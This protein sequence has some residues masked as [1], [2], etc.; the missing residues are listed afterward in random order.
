M[1]A[2]PLTRRY[3]GEAPGRRRPR[4]FRTAR[5]E[6]PASTPAATLIGS[7]AGRRGH[8]YRFEVDDRRRRPIARRA[9]ARITIANRNPN[10][11]QRGRGGGSRTANPSWSRARLPSI[12]RICNRFARVLGGCPQ[13]EYNPRSGRS[14]GGQAG[15]PEVPGA[16]YLRR[17]V[18]EGVEAPEKRGRPGADPGQKGSPWRRGRS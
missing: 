10:R 7:S 3:A 9:L 5:H 13:S 15:S 14:A 1:T 2:A 11:K 17:R 4:V 18:S 16:T 8:L 6:S 12:L